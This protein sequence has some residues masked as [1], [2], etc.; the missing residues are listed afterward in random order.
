MTSFDQL[1][2]QQAKVKY[3]KR[4][5]SFKLNRD[6]DREMKL[7]NNFNVKEKE[8]VFI[9]EDKERGF[10]INPKFYLGNKIV[11]M[12]RGLTENIF[13]Y[14]TLVENAK[15]VHVIE[16]CLSFI[17]DSIDLNSNCFIHRYARK[18]PLFETPIYK[19]NKNILV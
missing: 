4:W 10:C 19:R 1:F 5:N 17:I 16:S 11:S 2:Y 14:L 6:F 12:Q 7:F 18:I 3:Q 9:H 8:Y 15:E 13:D